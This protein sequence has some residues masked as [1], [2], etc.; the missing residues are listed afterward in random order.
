MKHFV[1][2]PMGA[3]MSAI[4]TG[5]LKVNVGRQWT[6]YFANQLELPRGIISDFQYPHASTCLMSHS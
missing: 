5:G 6:G 4:D 2:Q 3:L 1:S